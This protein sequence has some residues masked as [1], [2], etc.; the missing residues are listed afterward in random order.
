MMA[1][2]KRARQRTEE[3]HCPHGDADLMVRHGARA[4]LKTVGN[5]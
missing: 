4:R 3:I 5:I 2:A 1:T